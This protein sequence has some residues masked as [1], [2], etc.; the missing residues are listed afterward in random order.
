MTEKAFDP[1]RPRLSVK[2]AGQEYDLLGTLELVE[3]A[4]LA[5]KDGIVQIA[6]RLVEMGVTDVST[7]L[8]AMLRSCG[9]QVSTK[10][11]GRF[12]LDDLG[13][14]SEEFVFMK[15]QLFGFLRVLLEPPSG[16]EKVAKQMGEMLGEW[17]GQPA[18]PG[19]NISNS[20]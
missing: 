2:V 7:L 1:A 17:T 8:A 5:M 12:I 18:S 16:R 20:A 10:E 13:A 14:G 4:E 11:I 3:A 9:H 15:M 19:L 6:G